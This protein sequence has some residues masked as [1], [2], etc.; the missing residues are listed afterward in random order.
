M[1]FS[2]DSD[3]PPTTCV[4]ALD[5]IEATGFFV[6]E[7]DGPP[8]LSRW[9]E[10]P[11]ISF[12]N[13]VKTHS[14]KETIAQ[15]RNDFAEMANLQVQIVTGSK[16]SNLRISIVEIS[17]IDE[18]IQGL[19]QSKSGLFDSLIELVRSGKNS[20]VQTWRTRDQRPITSM[21]IMVMN[22]APDGFTCLNYI[23]F[24]AAGLQ[25]APMGETVSFL[26]S[27]RPINAPTNTDWT[28]LKL[29]YSETL[30]DRPNKIDWL[31]RRSELCLR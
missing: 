8:R 7:S 26:N 31:S 12:I 10:F 16:P 5:L 30:K 21:G 17:E 14:T 28:A 18:L 20:I 19:A 27:N 23:M 6:P 22:S 15:L 2:C 29:L 4:R 25:Q 3:Q 1:L 24:S 9:P 11:Q 13:P